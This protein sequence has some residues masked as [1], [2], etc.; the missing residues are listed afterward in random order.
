MPFAFEG[1][2]ASFHNPAADAT[3]GCA[4]AVE[5]T[6]TY[7][8]RIRFHE[9]SAVEVLRFGGARWDDHRADRYTSASINGGI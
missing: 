4:H 8:P 5:C 3:L 2:R 6:S 9:E 1:E 7:Y